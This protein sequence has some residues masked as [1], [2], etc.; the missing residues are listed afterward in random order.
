MD[1]Y[2]EYKKGLTAEE[3]VINYFI[4]KGW[5]IND[6]RNL[7]MYRKKDI[8]IQI[9]NEEC[10]F[11]FEIKA[12]N[13][14]KTNNEIVLEMYDLIRNKVGWF[15]TSETDYYIFVNPSDAE[16]FI[17]SSKRLKEWIEN[18]KPEEVF[19]EYSKCIVNYVNLDELKD[20]YQK[21][22]L[23]GN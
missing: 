11:F 22:D 3:L 6:L 7:W 13:R 15:Y 1:F 20:I 17:I 23:R 10:S 14:I 9:R 4:K 19:N 8:D 16:G 18:N 5:K 12:Q 21:I 2:A